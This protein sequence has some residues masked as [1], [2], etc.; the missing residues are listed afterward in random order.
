MLFC[1]IRRRIVPKIEIELETR[2]KFGQEWE[3]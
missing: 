2:S 1:G 3:I